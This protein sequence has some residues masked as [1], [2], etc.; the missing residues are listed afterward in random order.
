MTQSH[1]LQLLKK[2]SMTSKELSRQIGVTQSSI[3][4]CLKR[5]R[6]SGNVKLYTQNCEIDK[7]KNLRGIKNIIFSLK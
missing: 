6:K 3:N 7:T 4:M 1:I 2:K 5:L